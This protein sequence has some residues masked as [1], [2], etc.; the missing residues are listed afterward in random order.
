MQYM[1]YYYY[2]SS[3]VGKYFYY[4]IIEC[5]S[6]Y[7]LFEVYTSAVV[8]QIQQK[9]DIISSDCKL[10]TSNFLYY[11]CSLFNSIPS[12]CT[13]FRKK[14]FEINFFVQQNASKFAIFIEKEN[15]RSF[16][17]FSFRATLSFTLSVRT[18]QVVQNFHYKHNYT[19]LFIK[20][21]Q[22]ILLGIP[23]Y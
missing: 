12:T 9:I 15:P 14:R 10:N 4:C 5:Q 1:L 17:R 19:L 13:L 23:L 16:F 3:M 6:E 8:I 21:A 2:I 11:C 22:L 20:T 18:I 7:I